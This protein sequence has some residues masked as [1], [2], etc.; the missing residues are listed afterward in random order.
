MQATFASRVAI[1]IW[2]SEERDE[3]LPLYGNVS[4]WEQDA[5]ADIYRCPTPVSPH[6]CPSPQI[7]ILSRTTHALPALLPDDKV[8]AFGR[9]F[10]SLSAG[11][12][13]M[14]EGVGLGVTFPVISS[15]RRRSKSETNA[16][17]VTKRSTAATAK[18]SKDV[19]PQTS[20]K[21]G[22]LI[23]LYRPMLSPVSEERNT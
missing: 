15:S 2:E 22:G 11:G 1:E 7:K 8:P 16:A 12:V 4:W 18:A 5:K 14:A 10:R 23:P 17:I 21:N 9:R 20:R 6:T 3:S 13:L 19:M